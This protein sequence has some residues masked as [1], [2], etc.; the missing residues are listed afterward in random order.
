MRMSR[1]AK[2]RLRWLRRAHPAVSEQSVT[3]ALGEGRTLGYDDRG[4]RRV[5]IE[6]GSTEIVVVID[7]EAELVIT[8]WAR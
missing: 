8:L 4:H 1:H 6:A 2:N 7:E 3:E 5:L